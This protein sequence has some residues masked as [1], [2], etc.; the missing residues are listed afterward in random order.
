MTETS[1]GRVGRRWS[2]RQPLEAAYV[3]TVAVL[4]AVGFVADWTPPIALAAL[5]SLP[6]SLLALPGFYLAYGLLALVP[7]ANPDHSSGSGSCTAAG[8]C[9]STTTGDPATWLVVTADVLGIV[10]LTAAGLLNVWALRRLRRPS[11]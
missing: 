10:A 7:G 9:T 5:V 2:S 1:L 6:A 4:A 3:L 8:D 11:R